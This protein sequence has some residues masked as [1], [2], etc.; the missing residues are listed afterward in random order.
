MVALADVALSGHK[1]F[2]G[3]D[4]APHL[5][6]DKQSDCGCAGVY[7]A[8]KLI[9]ILADFFDFNNSLPTLEKFVSTNGADF[10]NVPYNKK[11]YTLKRKRLNSSVYR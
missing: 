3:S 7:N 1:S 10:Y 11:N 8:H 5:V 2:L 6:G 9:E 4:S